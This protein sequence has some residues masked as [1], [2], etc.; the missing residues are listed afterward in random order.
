MVVDEL[1]Q[2]RYIFFFDAFRPVSPGVFVY[3]R[4]TA[5]GTS[6]VALLRYIDN[7]GVEVWQIAELDKRF[8]LESGGTLTRAFT[9]TENN[10]ISSW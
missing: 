1:Y 8:E 4:I 10:L 9:I 5:I 7:E 3:P 2:G 6:K